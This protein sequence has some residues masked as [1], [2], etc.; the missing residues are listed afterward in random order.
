LNPNKRDRSSNS[1][2]SFDGSLDVESIL[3]WIDKINGLFD[4]E[5]ISMEDQVEFVTY[6]L[7]ERAVAWWNQFQNI[8]MTKANPTYKNLKADKKTFTSP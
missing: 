4:M 1:I 3:L 2:P 5:Y 6:K 7:K 8:H